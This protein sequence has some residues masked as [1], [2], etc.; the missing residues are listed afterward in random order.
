MKH[1]VLGLAA[2]AA[3]IQPVFA[4]TGAGAP[5]DVKI[6]PFAFQASASRN[7]K[8]D[9]STY[10]YPANDPHAGQVNSNVGD[11][12]L[13]GVVINGVTYTKDQIQLVS[14]AT[15][16][17][18][19][20][21]DVVRGG[22]N[23]AAGYGIGADRDSWVADGAATTTPSS[24]DLADNFG[25]F[26]LTSIVATREAVGTTI[27]E[28]GFA[29]PT[30]TLL[31][32]ERGSSGDVL[33]SA[34]NKDGRVLGS[35]KVRDGENDAGRK[36]DY[37]P[38]GIVVTTFVKEGFVNDGQELGSVGLRFSEPVSRFRFT[39]YQEPEGE[40]GSRFNGADLKVFALRSRRAVSAP[41]Q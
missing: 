4:Q 36:S 6:T 8:F 14:S 1:V 16:V 2:S 3:L 9:R 34:L 22:G 29:T 28:V 20:A 7:F 19:D 37:V 15:I 21:V 17:I 32:F 41:G 23:L 27:Y 35:Y 12:R 33:V 31:L 25:N 26:N 11:V 10:R 40:G 24:G 18:D 38:T 13:D 30:D 5:T 39:S